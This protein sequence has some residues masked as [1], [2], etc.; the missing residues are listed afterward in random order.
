METMF[1]NK[2]NSKTYEP[3]KFAIKLSQR[4][5]LRSSNKHAALGKRSKINKQV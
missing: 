1:I 2:E 3:Y 4:L 5:D